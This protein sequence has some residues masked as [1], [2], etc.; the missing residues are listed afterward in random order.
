[1]HSEEE[2]TDEFCYWYGSGKNCEWKEINEKIYIFQ[3]WIQQEKKKAKSQRL[4]LSIKRRNRNNYSKR[5][6]LDWYMAWFL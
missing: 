3:I 2:R 6:Y 1:V 4:W 5:I